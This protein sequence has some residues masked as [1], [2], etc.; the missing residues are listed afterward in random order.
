MPHGPPLSSG[1]GAAS[2]SPR[3]E[4]GE[5]F[6]APSAA[7]KA[8]EGLDHALAFT[9]E[10]S[11]VRVE[12]FGEAMHAM[13]RLGGELANVDTLL[14]A[15]Y[16]RLARE[17]H[18]LKVAINLGQ[19]WRDQADVRVVASLATSREACART[20][21]EAKAANRRHEAAE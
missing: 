3:P 10:C 21:E 12:F 4:V 20:L 13:I 18:Q 16:R 17:W 2:A 15:E 11:V 5:T 1:C 6:H 19:L 7:P 8:K 14:E 9:H